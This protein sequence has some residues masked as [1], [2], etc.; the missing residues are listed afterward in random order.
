MTRVK[1]GVIALK[2]RRNV[3]KQA[4]GYRFGRKSKERL[5]KTAITKAGAYAFAH[6]RD[7]KNDFRKQWNISIN[8][9]SRKE[10]ISYSVLIG[11]LKKQ[12]IELNRKMLALLAESHPETFH[13]ILAQ[14][15]K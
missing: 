2:R 4:K 15:K 9:E 14:I 10:N 12:K 13:R 8:A 5:A 11:T 1:R 3:L 7:R 6:R